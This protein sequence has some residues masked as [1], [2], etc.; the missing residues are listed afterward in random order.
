MA[1]SHSFLAVSVPVSDGFDPPS[2]AQSMLTDTFMQTAESGGVGGG[3]ELKDG[4]MEVEG[5]E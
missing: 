2:G 3:V 1:V 4:Y 5:S